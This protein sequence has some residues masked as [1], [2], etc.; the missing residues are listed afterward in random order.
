MKVNGADHDMLLLSHI[1]KWYGE[2]SSS[3]AASQVAQDGDACQS[4]LDASELASLLVAGGLETIVFWARD[5]NTLRCVRHY[6]N[7]GSVVLLHATNEDGEVGLCWR[8]LGDEVRGTLPLLCL[9][10]GKH[11]DLVGGG[12]ECVGDYGV[13]IPVACQDWTGSWRRLLPE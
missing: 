4:P 12:M 13:L 7:H 11:P 8:I 10:E 2:Y 1:F 5:R 9:S 6:A 3:F